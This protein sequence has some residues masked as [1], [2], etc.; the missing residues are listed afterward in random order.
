MSLLDFK[1]LGLRRRTYARFVRAWSKRRDR[2]ARIAGE[3]RRSEVPLDLFTPFLDKDAAVFRHTVRK[4]REHLN[5]PLGKHY[6][7]GPSSP[8]TIALCAELE[9]E[10]VPEEEVLG[11]GVAKLEPLFAGSEHKRAGWVYQQLL[12]LSADKV[13]TSDAILVLDADTV[14]VSDMTFERD[15]RYLLQYS[16]GFMDCYDAATM[17]IL[18]APTLNSF[19]F[20]CHHMVMRRCLL[21][22]LKTHIEQVNGMPWIDAVIRAVDPHS[23]QPLSEY[24]LYG[25]FALQERPQE[26]FLE[27][28]F[29]ASLSVDVEEDCE[30]VFRRYGQDHR[31]VSLHSYRQKRKFLDSEEAQP[32]I[33]R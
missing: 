30:A 16:E 13:A 4:A 7:V 10:F 31:T 27:Y 21:E 17:N 3:R 9:C 33:S 6:V 19:S 22:A 26:H 18:G 14:F 15:G 8:K 28:W 25:N 24:E 1:A 23:A 2:P 5:H 29:N 32:A 20:V 11:F 12:K